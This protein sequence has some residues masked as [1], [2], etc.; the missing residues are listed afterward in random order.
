MG[1]TNYITVPIA[2]GRYGFS[3]YQIHA[4]VVNKKLKYKIFN[5]QV[6]IQEESLNRFEKKHPIVVEFM[7]QR[8]TGDL[9]FIHFLGFVQDDSGNFFK[10]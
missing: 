3:Q 6:M 5:K 2:A 1:N 7:R 10:G 9:A 4:L 8:T